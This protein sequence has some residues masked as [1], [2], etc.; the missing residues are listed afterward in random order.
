MKYHLPVTSM[1]AMAIPGRKMAK[2]ACG[3]WYEQSYLA[4]ADRRVTCR[5]CKKTHAYKENPEVDL[6]VRVG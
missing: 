6:V 2:S 3:F 4:L 1:V 5:L